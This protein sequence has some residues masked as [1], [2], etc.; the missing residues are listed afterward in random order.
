MASAIA[1][2]APVV[3]AAA[4][5]AMAHAHAAQAVSLSQRAPSSTVV[6]PL[7]ELPADP[8]LDV[9]AEQMAL[10]SLASLPEEVRAAK[11]PAVKA[12]ILKRLQAQANKS[13]FN[14]GPA[15]PPPCS[16]TAPLSGATSIF[17]SSHVGEEEEDIERPVGLRRPPT[18]LPPPQDGVEACGDDPWFADPQ[19]RLALR[20]AV[21]VAH[22][23]LKILVRDPA[24]EIARILPRDG[25]ILGAGA[26]LRLGGQHLGGYG[27]ADIKYAYRQLSRALHPD[28]NPDNPDASEAFKRLANAQREL[29]DGLAHARSTLR[30]LSAPFRDGAVPEEELIRP[31]EALFAESTHLLSAI[32]AVATEGIVPPAARQRAAQHLKVP[33]TS[34][35]GS[36]AVAPGNIVSD[37]LQS[38]EFL[39][40]YGTP[41]LRMAYDCAAKRYRAHFLCTLARLAQLE[42]RTRC[43]RQVW[44]DVF[45]SFPE[46]GLWEKLREQLKWKCRKHRGRRDRSRSP[47]HARDV[48]DPFQDQEAE[49]EAPV[50]SKW[51]ERWRKMIRAVFPGG[52]AAAVA[53]SDPELRKLCAALWRDF[54]DPLE[55]GTTN[56]DTEAA[57]RALGLFK[58]E[59]RGAA[60]ICTQKGA[61]PPEWAFVP[62][63]DI[64]LI[65]GEGMIGITAEGV[66]RDGE[67][68]QRMPFASAIF[69]TMMG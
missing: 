6:I 49:V 8:D 24:E 10:K 26:V 47:R 5:A 68:S 20:D 64:L 31:Q 65:V 57:K 48:Y 19:I 44:A 67:S 4:A 17:V 43:I 25:Y 37:W 22:S 54:V 60:D 14:T 61:A 41:W 59:S 55:R 1:T 69:Q 38:S 15:P 53:W 34:G 30:K 56:P 40:A 3:A 13:L 50:W 23:E 12:G 28:K 27:D 42:D 63:A 66:F 16:R 35:G 39:D 18:E 62:A 46:M 45:T 29:Q 52:N 7:Q 33:T 9:R 21:E 36:W 51:A 2:A 11:M 32:L 58:T